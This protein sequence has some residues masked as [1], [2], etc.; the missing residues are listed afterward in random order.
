MTKQELAL[1]V[2]ERLKKE[3]PAVLPKHWEENGK[4][5]RKVSDTPEESV[6]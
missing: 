2:I 1:E 3:Y 4:T 5:A 6:P